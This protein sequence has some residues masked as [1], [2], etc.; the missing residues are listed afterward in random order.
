MSV[1]VSVRH[2]RNREISFSAARKLGRFQ[3]LSCVVQ[4]LMSTLFQCE[5][6]EL[7][8]KCFVVVVKLGG[9]IHWLSIAVDWYLMYV[10]VLSILLSS[11][12]TFT[13]TAR[14]HTMVG[15]GTVARWGEHHDSS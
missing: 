2:L 10:V 12:H 4:V 14:L 9:S 13:H 1:C 11:S 15:Q 5:S 6:E 7:L 8:S 3:A